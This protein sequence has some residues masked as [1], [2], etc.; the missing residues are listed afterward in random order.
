MT[1]PNSGGTRKREQA[2]GAGVWAGQDGT[3]VLTF[4]D[5]E[6]NYTTRSHDG[7]ATWDEPLVLPADCVGALHVTREGR[8]WA[9]NFVGGA[10][11]RSESIDAGR[12][13]GPVE[14]VP[15][16]RTVAR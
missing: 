11:R 6:L 7:G 9:C 8:L 15:V 16:D 12:A 13:W 14:G 5:R 1:G 4:D 2:N 10:F 3:L